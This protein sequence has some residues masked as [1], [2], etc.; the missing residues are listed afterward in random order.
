MT[1]SDKIYKL[2]AS[3]GKDI[4]DRIVTEF[5]KQGHTLTGS[6]IKKTKDQSSRSNDAVLVDVVMPEYYVFT[7][8][9]VKRSGIRKMYNPNV[10]TGKK[11]SNY[12]EALIHFF[13]LKG[14]S[15]KE[16]KSAAFATARVHYKEGMSTRASAKYSQ[17]GKRKEWIKD[18][19][20][21]DL[22]KDIQDDA[23][24]L[25]ASETDKRLLELERKFSKL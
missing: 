6:L 21:G 15:T 12:I 4:R 23:L 18:A 1:L 10:R 14:K 13:R 8:Y 3:K 2:L 9:G 17:T 5:Q 22:I 20:K 19:T 7:E 11:K 25:V 24:D 16:A